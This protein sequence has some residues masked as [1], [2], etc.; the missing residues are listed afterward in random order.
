MIRPAVVA[1]TAVLLASAPAAAQ[2]PLTQRDSTH[3]RLRTALRAFY[4]SLAHQDWEAL[5]AEI[6]PAKVVA[7]HP[8]PEALVLAAGQPGH[9]VHAATPGSAPAATDPPGCST[10]ATAVV[11]QAIITL[12]R[13]WAEVSVPRCGATTGGADEFRFIRFEGRWW[14]VYIELFRT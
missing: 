13:D 6:L 4:F 8:A 5:S 1:L 2:Q 14:I 3:V 10:N 11:E 7:H 9:A 12:D